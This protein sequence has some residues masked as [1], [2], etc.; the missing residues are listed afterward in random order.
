ML[1]DLIMSGITNKAESEQ[2]EL[3]E[4]AQIHE[5]L[6]KTQNSKA[7]LKRMYKADGKF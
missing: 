7:E 3:H 2:A 6:F 5:E 4:Q 1:F